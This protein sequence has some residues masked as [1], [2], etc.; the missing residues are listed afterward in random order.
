MTETP[1]E[2]QALS[3]E[4]EARLRT[5][6]K[7]GVR[8]TEPTDTIHRLLATLDALRV[9]RDSAGAGLDER[10]TKIGEAL[11]YLDASLDADH[12]EGHECDVCRAADEL[13]EA[14]FG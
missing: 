2:P 6:W 14:V 9:S 13:R 1:A 5:F 3:A 12:P 8:G 11:D 4:E 10:L 7:G